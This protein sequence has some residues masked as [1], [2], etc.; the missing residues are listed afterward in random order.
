MRHSRG[1]FGLACA[2]VFVGAVLAGC[3][4]SSGGGGTPTNNGNKLAAGTPSFTPPAGTYTTAQTVTLSDVTAGATI[5][6]T[7]NGTTPTTNSTKYTTPISVTTTETIN[8]IAVASGFLNSAEGTATYTISPT[9]STTATP[10]FSPAAGT[11]ETTQSVT[12]SDTTPSAV[13]YYTTDGSTP[14][15]AS[16][17]YTGAISVATTETVKAV[18]AAPGYVTS[19]VASAAYTILTPGSAAAAP[20]FSPAAGQYTT[21]SEAITISDVTPGANIYYTTDGSTPSTSSTKYTAAISLTES[22]T[23]K[24]IATANGYST[25]AVSSAAYTIIYP[26]T[27]SA[28][29]TTL[30]DPSHVLL[31]PNGN[32]LISDMTGSNCVKIIDP[33]GNI[34]ATLG[35]PGPP[36]SAAGQFDGPEGLAASSTNGDIYVVDSNNSRVEI[37][38]ENGTYVSSFGSNLLT[39]P[40]SV[41]VDSSGNAYVVDDIA[42]AVFEF[43]AAGT[44]VNTFGNSGTGKLSQPIDIIMTAGG[45]LLVDD[46]GNNRV[47]EFTTAGAYV[48]SFGSFGSGNGQFNHPVGICFDSHGNLYVNDAG[49]G[50]IEEFS[51]NFTFLY[52]YQYRTPNSVSSGQKTSLEGFGIYVDSTGKIYVIMAGTSYVLPPLT[53]QPI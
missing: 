6:Y 26:S 19:A 21:Q 31:L 39:D 36:S 4:G 8:A 22:A 51:S 46:M 38:T 13:I 23:V 2:A 47:V 40:E 43:N 9:A 1:R 11:Y 48:T 5:Y 37:F 14:T 41:A 15:T 10:T 25:S 18:A 42:N 33:A 20:T 35:T 29:S 28:G 24:A 16:T 50:R 17:K 53:N 7:L 45:N 12:I 30:L 34:V 49:N 27:P 32:L 3:S 52:S 44:L